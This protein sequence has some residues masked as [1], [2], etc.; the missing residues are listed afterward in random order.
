VGL[1]EVD[2]RWPLICYLLDDPVYHARYVAY[3]EAVVD[4]PFEPAQMEATYRE[5]GALVEPYVLDE[6]E[7]YTFLRSEAAFYEAIEELV[8]HAYARQEAVEA[9]LATQR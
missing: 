7:G 8:D 4:G 2:E 9:Y 3:V 6:T 1:D 5:L